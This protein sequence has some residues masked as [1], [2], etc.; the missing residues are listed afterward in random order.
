MPAL[1]RFVHVS[2]KRFKAFN[3][4]ALPLRRFNIL[5]GPNNAGKSTVLASFRILAAAVRRGFARSPQLV[6]GPLGQTFGYPVDL[7]SVSVAEESIFHNYDDSKPATVDFRLASGNTLTLY[8]PEVGRC[9]LIPDA[10][11]RQIRTAAAFRASF[12]C[13]IGFVP[14]LGPVEQTERLY[15]KAAARL[16]LFNYGAARNF[17]NIWYHYS[18]HF[19]S[20]RDLL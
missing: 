17:R 3:Q 11:G 6:R 20:F 4:F 5:V 2:F 1:D 8:F 9:L 10:Q 18:E 14:I 7:S 15:E 16:A 13:P 12:N 19:T